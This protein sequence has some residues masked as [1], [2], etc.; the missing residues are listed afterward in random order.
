M[1]RDVKRVLLAAGMIL[2]LSSFA[3]AH[4]ESSRNNGSQPGFQQ[5]Y[6]DGFQHGRQDRAQRLGYDPRGNN[7]QGNRSYDPNY[8]NNGNRGY[9]PYANG[10][11]RGN[12]DYD[13]DDDNDGNR[14]NRGQ[15][16]SGYRQGYRS[17]YDDG[18][19]GR[20]Q[21]NG[22]YGNGGYGNGGYGNGRYGGYGSQGP[23]YN[24]GAYDTGYRDGRDGAQQDIREN[25]RFD[26]NSHG[27]YRDGDHG[28]SSVYGNRDSYRQQYRQ[29]YEAG[30]REVFDRSGYSNGGYGGTGYPNG[31]Y[32]NR[33]SS[34][35][36]NGGY[37]GYP[38]G[39]YGGGR[40]SSDIASSTGYSDGIVGARKDM[41][42]RKSPDPT[43]HDWYQ[44][45]NRGYDGRAY[46]NRDDYKQRYRQAYIAGYN[47][48]FSGRARGF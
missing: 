28:Y 35:Y 10:G 41:L 14:G 31:G 7:R 22:A 12:R 44:D 4:D 18:Y 17:G 32:P 11:S 39:G 47:D 19:Y 23:G 8:G 37:G 2:A 9:D 34:G 5:G 29:G 24:N 33:G 48:T 26:V 21:G 25:K 1:L 3:L 36:P 13:R 6:N 45:A 43:R 27:W 16:A 30:Y 38:N 15:S 42:E 40:G 20:N 46:G